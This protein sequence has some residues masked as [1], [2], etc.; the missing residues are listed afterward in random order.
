MPEI[1]KESLPAAPATQD[2]RAYPT[3]PFIGVGVVVWKGDQF[4]LIQRGKPPR[5]GQWSIP[6][7]GQELGET[8]RETAIRE[9]KEET[10]V[11]I[12]VRGLI[13][14]VDSIRADDQNR[15]A[16]HIT[17]IDF[18]ARWTGGEP[19]AGDDAMG[20]G[21]FKLADLPALGLW[22][23]TVRVIEESASCL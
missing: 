14:V 22:D 9:V 13:D 20:V 6:G 23:E 1:A 5:M 10:G 21:W 7:G 12:E 18:A 11:D 17:L 15:I 19:V 16:Y 4:L 8:V 3:R 2:A